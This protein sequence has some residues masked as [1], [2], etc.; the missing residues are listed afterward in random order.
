L[1]PLRRET[2]RN[3]LRAVPI[4]PFDFNY[5]RSLEHCLVPWL[6]QPFDPLARIL[7]SED[8]S[9]ALEF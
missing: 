9:K 1:N 5:V 4:E 7:A 6:A 2:W 8:F 3:V